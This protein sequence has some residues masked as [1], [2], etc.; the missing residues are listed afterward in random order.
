MSLYHTFFKNAI[1]ISKNFIFFTFVK[2]QKTLP[3]IDKPIILIYNITNYIFF[4]NLIL[5]ISGNF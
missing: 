5:N 3:S 2:S 4:I 1:D